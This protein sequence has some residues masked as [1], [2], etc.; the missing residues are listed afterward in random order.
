MPRAG[1]RFRR[2]GGGTGITAAWAAPRRESERREIEPSDRTGWSAEDDVSSLSGVDDHFG[3]LNETAEER[4]TRDELAPGT[5]IGGVTIVRLLAEGGMGRVYEGRQEAPSRTVAVKVMRDGLGTASRTRRFEYEAR[6]LARLRHPNIAHI[7]M[8]GTYVDAHGAVPF[9]V[10]ELVE[11]GLP[12]T[13][14]ADQHGLSLT[15][16]VTLFRRVCAAVAHGHQKGIIHRDLKPGN[17][18]VGR[19]GEPKVIDFG[20]CA[21][22][23]RGAPRHEF[24]DPCRRP[25]GNDSLHESGAAWRR[26]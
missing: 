25:R 6:M 5:N 8:F 26:R 9:F 3:L 1:R 23:R 4:F 20:V 24:P 17:V 16:R 7:H 18:L 12:I 15:E 10:M 22:D 21:I 19:D 11:D 2:R 13:R 14:Y